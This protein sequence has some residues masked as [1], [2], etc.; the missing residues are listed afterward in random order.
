MNQFT[1]HL[2]TSFLFSSL[3]L[4][5]TLL[6]WSGFE[7]SVYQGYFCGSNL[8][9]L[10]LDCYGRCYNHT[11]VGLPRVNDSIVSSIKE[12]HMQ[13][14]RNH[15][16]HLIVSLGFPSKVAAAKYLYRQPCRFPLLWIFRSSINNNTSSRVC[17]ILNNN[18][19]ITM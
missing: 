1:G 13:S 8:A 2:S 14:K 19:I 10:K 9:S 18:D 12:G 11:L 3:G 15:V 16:I 7:P 17:F 6:K 5:G 4:E